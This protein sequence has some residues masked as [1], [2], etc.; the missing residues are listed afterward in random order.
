M[1]TVERIENKLIIRFKGDDFTEC[2]NFVK[3]LQDRKFIKSCLYW[4]APATKQNVE[5]LKFFGFDFLNEVKKE[6]QPA[7][8][9][10]NNNKVFVSADIDLLYELSNLFTYDDFSYCYVGGA[11]NSRKIVKRKLF[12]FK[13]D[14][15]F[16]SIGVGFLSSIL[17]YF[18]DNDYEYTVYDDRDTQKNSF[19]DEEIKNN[20]SY[21][22]LYDYQVDA[23]RECIQRK[24]CIVKLPTS[25]GK[26][27]IFIS[28]CNLLKIKTLILF[29]RIDLAQQTLRRCQKAGLDAGIVQGDNVDEHHQIVM[30]TVQSSHK[31]TQSYEMAIVDE[32]HKSSSQSYQDILKQDKFVYRFGFSATPF[33]KDKY[34]TALTMLWLGDIEYTVPAELLVDEKKIAKPTINIIGVNRPFGIFDLGWLDVEYRG[35]V[36]NEFRNHKIVEICQEYKRD[37][38]ILVKRI[39]HGK[40][41][42]NMINNSIFLSG[43]SEVN[44]RVE[45]TDKFEKGDDVILIASTIFDEGISINRIRHLIIAGGGKSYVKTIQR[46]GRGLRIKDNKTTVSVYD[47]YDSTSR[48]L[49]SHSKERIKSYREE[50]FDD[51]KYA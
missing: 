32:C 50:G 18:E 2:L 36:N 8:V 22:Q 14:E 15:N 48:I 17:D 19:T 39:S 49:E 31:L 40:D 25:S 34:K 21:L 24:N 10:I 33:V 37:I 41:L 12:K 26:T 4:T 38:L 28:I 42:E 3:G 27:E 51:I 11:F 35:I 7:K 47:F 46:I 5:A 44:K 16:G 23:V 20:L 30:C 43:Q 6:Y 45:Y 29:S 13:I 9:G 1:K